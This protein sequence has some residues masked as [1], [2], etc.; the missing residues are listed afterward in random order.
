MRI[1]GLLP[2]GIYGEIF[3]ILSGRWKRVPCQCQC[4]RYPVKG[5]CFLKKLALLVTVFFILIVSPVF[6]QEDE[7]T[8]AEPD[9]TNRK[10]VT[11]NYGVSASWLTRI[12]KQTGR[13]NFVF[14]DFLPGVYLNT[15]L[16]NV[17]YILPSLRVTAYYP[18]LSTFNDMPQK[19]KTPLHFGLDF[20]TGI[21]FKFD[22][23][24]LRLSTGPGLHM[25]YMTADRWNYFNMGIAAALGVELAISAGWALIIDG[26]ASFDSG[27]LGK[28]RQME[29]FD[30]TY[31]Y[32]A[33]VGARYSKK[34]RSDTAIFMPKE[35]HPQVN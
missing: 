18:L 31:Q 16:Q 10:F 7:G 32:Q 8:E 33:A 17:R 35:K 12:I 15:E 3:Y 6:A 28:N 19:Q 25:F 1:C 26:F 14:R 34:K 21:R 27:N 9:K 23:K 2:N 5:R 29:P 30:I 22:W 20:F 13:S 11:F 4:T 24:I